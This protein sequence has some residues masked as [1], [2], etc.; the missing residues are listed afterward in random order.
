MAASRLRKGISYLQELEVYK[1]IISEPCRTSHLLPPARSRSIFLRPLWLWHY[2]PWSPKPGT[3]LLW[4]QGLLI[5]VSPRSYPLL[6]I[7]LQKLEQSRSVFFRIAT[8]ILILG[9]NTIAVAVV[10]NFVNSV[11]YLLRKDSRHASSNIYHGLAQTLGRGTE[12]L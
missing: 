12:L 9:V 5:E 11:L 2:Y 1:Y 6:D 7:Q 4:H 8:K 10:P 3:S